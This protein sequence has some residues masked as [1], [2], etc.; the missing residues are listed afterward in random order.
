MVNQISAREISLK[1]RARRREIAF[2]SSRNPKFAWGSIPRTSLGGS[3]PSLLNV[4][5]PKHSPLATP[6]NLRKNIRK[7]IKKLYMTFK[8]ARCGTRIKHNKFET[9]SGWNII[10]LTSFQLPQREQLTVPDRNGEKQHSITLLNT[11]QKFCTMEFRLLTLTG[12]LTQTNIYRVS[13]KKVLRFDPQQLL[14]DWSN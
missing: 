2:P 6:L 13:Q 1:T 8:N 14:N 3:W 5:P 11:Q 4:R 10:Y 12:S 9:I 7:V